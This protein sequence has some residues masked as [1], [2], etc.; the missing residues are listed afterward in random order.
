M[1]GLLCAGVDS[2]VRIRDGEW[3]RVRRGNGTYPR[4]RSSQGPRALCSCDIGPSGAKALC[5]MWWVVESILWD[6]VLVKVEK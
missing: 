6:V 1:D 4:C 5:W 3:V 2:W